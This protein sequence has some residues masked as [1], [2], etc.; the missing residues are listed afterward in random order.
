M[1]KIPQATTG[2]LVK[3]TIKGGTFMETGTNTAVF[4]FSRLST[5]FVYY[6]S[7]N[8]QEFHTLWKNA[9]VI[10]KEEYPEYFL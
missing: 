10:S 6:T 9:V 4:K 5:D 2:D 8:G 3:V 7:L 1:K